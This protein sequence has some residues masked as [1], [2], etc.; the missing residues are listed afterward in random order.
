MS[1][2]PGY[3]QTSLTGIMTITGI[4]HAF[5]IHD[6]VSRRSGQGPAD[7]VRISTSTISPGLSPAKFKLFPEGVP[8]C[9][10]SVV[11]TLPIPAGSTVQE[12]RIPLVFGAQLINA[13]LPPDLA[14]GVYFVKLSINGKHEAQRLIITQ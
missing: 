4:G 14:K 3:K 13:Q 7:C 11:A 2:V 1:T 8:I 6:N 10:V 12:K 9:P 5:A